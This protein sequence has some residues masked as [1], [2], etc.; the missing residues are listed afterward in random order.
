MYSLLC[1]SCWNISFDLYQYWNADS[2]VFYL[3]NMNSICHAQV[4][5][6]SLSPVFMVD[7]S[8]STG[9]SIL[10]YV[11]YGSQQ[12]IRNLYMYGEDIDW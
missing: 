11:T 3:F 12:N 9:H 5:G 7:I 4:I 6:R 1:P 2:F 10:K 8:D